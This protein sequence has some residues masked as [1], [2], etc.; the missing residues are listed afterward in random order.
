MTRAGATSARSALTDMAL[1]C[2]WTVTPSPYNPTG[3]TYLL[4]GRVKILVHWHAGGAVK[5]ATEYVDGQTRAEVHKGDPH[6]RRELEAWVTGPPMF[7]NSSQTSVTSTTSD[8]P[9]PE[10]T[11]PMTNHST[12]VTSLTGMNVAALQVAAEA[13]G[14]D[15]DGRITITATTA[16]YDGTPADALGWLDHAREVLLRGGYKASRHPVRS[17]AAVRR[18]FIAAS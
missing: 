16:T 12:K 13:T 17:L 6:R 18:K 14:A 3:S 1:M 15:T 10:R 11:T 8:Q 2:E 4:R 5:S 7:D 9:T